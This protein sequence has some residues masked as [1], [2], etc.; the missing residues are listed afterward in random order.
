MSQ[1]AFI[2]TLCPGAEQARDICR[3]MLDEQLIACANRMA[4]AISH[5]NWEGRLQTE[6]EYPV[7]M[8]TSPEK[9]EA[10]MERLRALHSY[11]TPPITGWLAQASPEFAR[12]A[13]EETGIGPDQKRAPRPSFR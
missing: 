2:Y 1:I 3:M 7:L 10:A 13:G 5:Y 9:M 11:D 12:W 6:E 8:K 4:P